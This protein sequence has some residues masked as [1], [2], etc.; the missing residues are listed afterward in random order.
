MITQ[1]A[2]TLVEL[3]VVIGIIGI[4]TALI[5]P[6][7]QSARESGRRTQCLNNIRQ[8]GIALHSYTAARGRMPAG[9]I[10]KPYPAE[11]SHPHNFYR[12]SAL[13]QLLP[14]LEEGNAYERIDLSLPLYGPSLGVM[15]Q[16]QAAVKQPIPIFLCPSD[17]GQPVSQDFAPTN[18]AVCAGSGV[19][20]GTPFD[21]DGLFYIN[22]ATPTAGIRDGTSKTIAVAESLLGGERISGVPAGQIDAERNY[23]FTFATPLTESACSSSTIYNF[24]D[25]RGFSWANG[26]YRCAL[27]NHHLPPNSPTLDCM[28]AVNVGDLSVRY[29]A[30][31]WRAARSYHPGQV[32]VLFADGSVRPVAETIDLDVWRAMS[33][34][35]GREASGLE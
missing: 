4:L 12:W 3:L 35:A 29:S 15:P 23:A 1:R 5:L 22:S 32:N 8:M 25:P 11:P 30:Y 27:Y 9:S 13:A 20:G 28:A 16:N 19:G 10:S 2:F 17:H 34:R 7:V 6:A 14:Y 31:G 33:T 26:E 21:T 24:T 18:Y